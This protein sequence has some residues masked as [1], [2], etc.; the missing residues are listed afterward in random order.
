MC[1][2]S[3]FGLGVAAIEG[4]VALVLVGLL[5]TTPGFWWGWR[6]S[7]AGVAVEPD[8]LV[9]RNPLRTH[10]IRY[11]DIADVRMYSRFGDRR[12]RPRA[13]EVFNRRVGIV[14]VKGVHKPIEMQATDWLWSTRSLL[15]H[16]KA[17]SDEDV[18]AVRSAWIDKRNK[19]S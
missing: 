6:I 13:L 11:D 19:L 15:G 17:R 7:N 1:C 8:A 3:L 12:A 10:R 5:W 16:S 14:V 4:G 9:I 18:E 2:L